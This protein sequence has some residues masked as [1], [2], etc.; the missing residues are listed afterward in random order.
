MNS[1]ISSCQVVVPVG[2]VVDH[3]LWNPLLTYMSFFHS[4]GQNIFF[5]VLSLS[6]I[7]CLSTT[8]T[9]EEEMG[10]IFTPILGLGMLPPSSYPFPL[11]YVQS[12]RIG[13]VFIHWPLLICFVS[14]S[15]PGSITNDAFPGRTIMESSA[16][17]Q[18]LPHKLEAFPIISL[19]SRSMKKPG[20]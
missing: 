14:G 15:L 12:R 11:S 5:N 6:L 7:H 17:C 18:D 13:T 16:L 1:M 9:E 19:V 4:L 3:L 2:T 10:F 8:S 20:L